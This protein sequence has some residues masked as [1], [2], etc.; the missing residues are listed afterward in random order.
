[1]DQRRNKKEIIKYLETN[2]NENTTIQNLCGAT[3]T[4]LRGKFI[5][6]QSFFRKEEKSQINNLTYYLREL[7]KTKPKVSRGKEIIKISEITNKIDSIN[8]RKKIDQTKS[9]DFERVNKIVKPLAR[10]T[11]KRGRTQTNKIR[12]EKGE[13]STY[14]TE[15]Q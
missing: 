2:D 3:N 8:N 6:I 11:K 13:I 12:N 4:V 7:E 15:I 9:W 14:I 5:A 1:M 10:L